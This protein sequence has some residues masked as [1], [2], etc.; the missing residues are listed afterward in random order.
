MDVL[1]LGF[2]R[3]EPPTCK[4][5]RVIIDMDYKFRDHISTQYCDRQEVS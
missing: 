1:W 5:S 4:G 3:R 2:Y